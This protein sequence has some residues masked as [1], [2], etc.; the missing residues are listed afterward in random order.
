MD[1]LRAVICIKTLE[2]SLSNICLCPIYIL[3]SLPKKIMKKNRYYCLWKKIVGFYMKILVFLPFSVSGLGRNNFDC[4]DGFYLSDFFSSYGGES[5]F[6]NYGCSSLSQNSV[7]ANQLC[8]L[9]AMCTD[10]VFFSKCFPKI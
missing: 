9:P 3:F 7:S 5:R 1:I 2:T 6:Y 4:P 10:R 8:K